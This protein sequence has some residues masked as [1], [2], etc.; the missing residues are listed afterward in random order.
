MN[1]EVSRRL[2]LFNSQFHSQFSI[3]KTITPH[4]PLPNPTKDRAV[5]RNIRCTQLSKSPDAFSHSGSHVE[6]PSCFKFLKNP[7]TRYPKA[8]QCVVKE[9]A[10][11][12]R[13]EEVT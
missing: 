2:P 13:S 4:P 8:S 6:E 5:E 10:T 1:Y 11:S 7:N 3:L 12:I 9:S